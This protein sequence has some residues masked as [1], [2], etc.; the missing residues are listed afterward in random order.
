M[1]LANDQI[2]ILSGGII[3]LSQL[4]HEPNYPLVTCHLIKY[5]TVLNK[6][7]TVTMTHREIISG[8]CSRLLLLLLS[9][10]WRYVMFMNFNEMGMD[11]YSIS[12]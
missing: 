9:H 3:Y 10:L 4:D 12:L 1:S 5:V 7:G 6:N 8:S 2:S 11:S